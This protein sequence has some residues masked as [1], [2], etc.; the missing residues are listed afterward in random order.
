M[1]AAKGAEGRIDFPEL[2]TA[3]LRLTRIR[4]SDAPSVF[5]MF[6]DPDLRRECVYLRGKYH[7]MKCFGLIS[8]AFRDT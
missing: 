5:A 1:S 6:S 3:R 4:S 8:S 7:D 2:S